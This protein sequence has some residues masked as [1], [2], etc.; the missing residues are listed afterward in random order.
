MEKAEEVNC[1][2]EI[3]LFFFL[4]K[5]SLSLVSRVVSWHLD[6]AGCDAFC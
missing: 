4:S 1:S 2:L 5:L 3:A 6:G